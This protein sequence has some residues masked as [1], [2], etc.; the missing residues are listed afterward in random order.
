MRVAAS[1]DRAVLLLTAVTTLSFVGATTS[2]GFGVYCYTRPDPGVDCAVLTVL[3]PLITLPLGISAGVLAAARAGWLVRF[4][5]PDE[6]QPGEGVA[7]FA[8]ET[9]REHE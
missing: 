1:G 4:G 2:L 8:E 9:A 7:A 3:A 6:E 5:A